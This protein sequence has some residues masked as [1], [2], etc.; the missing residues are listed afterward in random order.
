MDWEQVLVPRLTLA[1][2]D[3]QTTD[4]SKGEQD[5]NEEGDK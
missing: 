2:E 4:Q 5:E 3:E 1:A